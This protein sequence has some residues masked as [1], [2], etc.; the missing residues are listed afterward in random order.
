MTL[1]F[2]PTVLTEADYLWGVFARVANESDWKYPVSAVVEADALSETIRAISVV[3]GSQTTVEALPHGRFKL[4]A[5]GYYV[6]GG[7]GQER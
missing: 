7:D 1:H 6:T 2:E 3:S 4:Y 5:P